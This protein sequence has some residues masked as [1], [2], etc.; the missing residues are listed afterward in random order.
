MSDEW[1]ELLICGIYGYD[2]DVLKLESRRECHSVGVTIVDVPSEL[3]SAV[4]K[5]LMIAF[6]KYAHDYHYKKIAL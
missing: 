3:K 4:D 2:I 1:F 6:F 5:D